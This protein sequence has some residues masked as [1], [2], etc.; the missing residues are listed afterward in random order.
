[1]GTL[2]KMGT[3]YFRVLRVAVDQQWDTSALA[4]M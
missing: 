3:K 1:M 4:L 2:P